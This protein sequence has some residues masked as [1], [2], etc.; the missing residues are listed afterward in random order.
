M[1]FLGDKFGITPAV[2]PPFIR[3]YTHNWATDIS[4]AKTELGYTVTPFKKAVEETSEW[5]KNKRV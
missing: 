1:Q 3:K 5:I 2:T 4:K